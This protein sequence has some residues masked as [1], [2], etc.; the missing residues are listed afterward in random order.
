MEISESSSDGMI[1][2]AAYVHK[3]DQS[4]VWLDTIRL[5]TCN[6]CTMKSGC[7]QRLMNQATDCKRSRIALPLADNVSLQ[8]GDE[9]VLGIPQQAF[10][11]ASLLTFAMPLVVLVLFAVAAQL[12]QFS[13]PMIV[14]SALLGLASG[15][16]LVRWYSSRKSVLNAS[17]WHP[18]ILR[19][20]TTAQAQEQELQFR[21]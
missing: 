14:V 6:S 17:Q 3:L 9:V 1:E 2:Q 15:L 16:L 13:E 19:K 12:S 21:P 8:V 11:K 7:G 20:Q 4:T 18:V 5:S 10:I